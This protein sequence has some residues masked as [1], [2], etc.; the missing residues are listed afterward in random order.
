MPAAQS[1][2]HPADH[3]AHQ[4]TGISP[5]VNS[6]TSSPIPKTMQAVTQNAYGSA[7]ALQCATV[8]TPV[9]AGK[10]ILIEVHAAGM[11]KGTW[12]LMSG[13]PYLIRLAGFG[14]SKPKQAVPGLDVAGKVVA[15]GS[16]VTRFNIGDEVYGI[17]KGSF[18]DYATASEDKL[19][20]KPANLTFEEA[21]VATV[22][23]ITALEALADQGKLQADQHVLVVGAS[24]G[25]GSYTV[26]LAKAHGAQVSAVASA[27]KAALV[28]SL[29]ADHVIDY[30]S[31]YL[32][33]SKTQYDLIID[34]GGRNR[35]SHLRRLLTPTG[36]L[37]FVGGEGGNRF[38]GGIGRQLFAS[39][40][41]VFYKQS[42]RMFV[43]TEKLAMMERF[44]KFLESGEVRPSVGARFAL[45]DVPQAMRQLEAGQISGKAVIVVRS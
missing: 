26:Q 7:E 44:R 32:T 1:T 27:S 14:F 16:E 45:N 25:V 11:D 6:D 22:S 31:D 12:Y 15:V 9:P 18:A 2:I 5:L 23:G 29:G 13:K 43:S 24:G 19:V 30:R 36:T 42:L 4:N 37:V 20:L 21:A 33:N 3:P 39:L 35:V 17:A 41:S 40:M 8:D 28:A 38:T 34:I 10:E